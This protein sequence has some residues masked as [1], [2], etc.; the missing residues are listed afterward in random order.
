[1]PKFN[2]KKQNM[3]NVI[4]A[5][6]ILITLA[7]CQQQQKIAFVDNGEVINKYQK[8]IDVEERFKS[9][10]LVF[11]KKRDSLARVY[12]LEAQA[13]Q[14]RLSKLSPQKQQEGSQEFTQKWQ[15]IQQQV[16]LEQQEMQQAFTTEIDSVVVKVKD[17][18]TEYGKNNGYT[19]ILGKNDAGSVMFGKEENDITDIIVEAINANNKEK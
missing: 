14:L 19:F 10:D 17:F 6:V 18:V 16:Q 15:I 1:M 12:Q 2:I 7:S 3:K 4:A 5:L 11:T 13:V 9:Q 8:K